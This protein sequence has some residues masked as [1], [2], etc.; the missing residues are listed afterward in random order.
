MYRQD[1]TQWKLYKNQI[2]NLKFEWYLVRVDQYA[3]TMFIKKAGEGS[4]ISLPVPKGP[5]YYELFVEAVLEKEVK[6][7]RS[8]LN[9]PLE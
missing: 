1:T 5:Q 2:K 6:T 3:N 9:T 4:S 7:A 8:T